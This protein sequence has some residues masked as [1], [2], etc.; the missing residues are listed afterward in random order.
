M[1]R[2]LTGRIAVVTGVSR[3]IG[4]GAAICRQLAADGAH[5]FFAYWRPYDE[6]MP[7]GAEPEFPA[8]FEDELQ[9]LGVRAAGLEVDLSASSAPR[10]LLDAVDAALGAPSI[11]VNNAAYST[12]TPFTELTPANL[13]AHY[14]VNVRATC[15]LSAEFAR[16]FRGGTGGRIISMTSGQSLGPMPD[17]L[18]YV[19]TKGAVEA[20]TVS[21]APAVAPLGIT[22]NAVNPGPV[23]TG[24]MDEKMREALVPKFPFGRV[25]RPEDAARLVAFLASDDG[26]WMTGQVLHSEGGFRD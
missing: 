8:R 4:I 6:V 3:S 16:R 12:M 20:F 17:E 13:D 7:W 22:V 1:N 21:L 10:Q 2:R 11:L 24:Y 18:A 9:L 25:G 23:D 26:A 19:A 15:M 14:A 5:V